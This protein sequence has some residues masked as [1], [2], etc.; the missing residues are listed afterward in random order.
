MIYISGVITALIIYTIYA[1]IK[2]LNDEINKDNYFFSVIIPG[3]VYAA[4]SWASIGISIV[5]WVTIQENLRRRNKYNGWKNDG[6]TNCAH[7]SE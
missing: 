3:I 6:T 7:A 5:A 2:V 4:F 1:T